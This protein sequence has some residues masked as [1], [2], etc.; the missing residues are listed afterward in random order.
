[1]PLLDFTALLQTSSIRYYSYPSGEA[2]VLALHRDAPDCF[3]V[4]MRRTS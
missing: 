4:D 1:M 3:L 2:R